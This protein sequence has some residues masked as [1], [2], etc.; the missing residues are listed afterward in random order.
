[1]KLGYSTWGMPKVPIDEALA[2]IAR[3]GYRGVEI[4]VIPGYTTALENLDPAERRRIQGILQDLGLDLPAIAAHRSM[5]AAEPEVHAANMAHLKGAVELAVDWAGDRPPALNT[6]SGGRRDEWEDARERLVDRMG[7]LVEHAARYGVTV[8]IEPHVGATLDSPEKTLWL[9]KRIGSPFLKVNFDFSHFEAV[10][11]P[12]AET[13]A[14]LG[15]HSAHT[16][17]KDTRGHHPNHEFLIPGESD[18]DYAAFLRALRAAGYD[19][20]ITVEVSV[21]VQRRP[22]YD[23]FAAAELG[24]RTL[25]AAFAEAFGS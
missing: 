21:M 13:V 19:G 14:A 5:L 8:A 22:D 24:Y 25:S 20:Y 6:T 12:M 18:F 23:P 2:G 17:V 3:M 10:G 16:H 1:M 7:E 4:T 9:L 11:L 15:P